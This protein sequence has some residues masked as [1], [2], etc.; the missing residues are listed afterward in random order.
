MNRQRQEAK[1]YYERVTS[2]GTSLL[3]LVLGIIAFSLFGWRFSLVGWRV[4]PGI[5]LFLGVLFTFFVFNYRV[6]EI[7]VTDLH[8]KLKFGLISWKAN[9][10]NIQSVEVDNSPPI[11]KYGG[12]GVHF[13]FVNGQYRAFFNFL[14]YT[15]VLATFKQKQGLVT[16]L[17]FTS[18]QPEAL[19]KII[20]SRINQE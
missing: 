10:G 11:I 19:F 2:S 16:A 8:L 5:L 17:V 9:L 6:L 14:E 12:A 1:I 3:F 18:R 15:R 7:T 4:F 13:A 20:K